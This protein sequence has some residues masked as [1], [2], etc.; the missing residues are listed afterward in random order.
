MI[1]LLKTTD[2]PKTDVELEKNQKNVIPKKYEV[3][4]K[5]YIDDDPTKNFKFDANI[6][7]SFQ[8]KKPLKTVILHSK[9]LIINELFVT[10]QSSHEIKKLISANQVEET[11]TDNRTLNDNS[12]N[13]DNSN[14]ND[15]I[16]V[17]DAVS[18]TQVPVT[19]LPNTNENKSNTALDDSKK[20]SGE[21]EKKPEEVTTTTT[22]SK[23]AEVITT[24]L[25]EQVTTTTKKTVATTTSTTTTT[26]TTTEKSKPSSG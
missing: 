21:T 23:P 4:I 7:I 20:I 24:K 10:Y 18:T 25:P 1:S 26:T 6:S 15:T 9:D 14:T 13:D 8:V 5:P 17:S 22:T 3:Y 12:L 11:G 2:L 16:K 19:E